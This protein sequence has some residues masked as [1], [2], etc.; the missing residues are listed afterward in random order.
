MKS[1]T[2]NDLIFSFSST[3]SDVNTKY[4]AQSHRILKQI[5]KRTTF[6]HMTRIDRQQQ[7]MKMTIKYCRNMMKNK[8]MQF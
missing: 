8:E 7:L 6:H 4:I 5:F 3:H 2:G 1:S